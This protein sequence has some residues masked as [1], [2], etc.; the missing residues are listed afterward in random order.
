MSDKHH[1]TLSNVG[2]RCASPNRRRLDPTHYQTDPR[3][4]VCSLCWQ[5]LFSTLSFQQLCKAAYLNDGAGRIVKAQCNWTRSL[6]DLQTS[7]HNDCQWCQ[8]VLLSIEESSLSL[9]DDRLAAGIAHFKLEGHTDLWESDHGSPPKKEGNLNCQSTPAGNNQLVLRVAMGGSADYKYVRFDFFKHEFTDKLVTVTAGAFQWQLRKQHVWQQANQWLRDCTKHDC[10]PMQNPEPLPSRVIDVAS[11][12]DGDIVSLVDGRGHFNYYAALSYPWG[13][14]QVGQTTGRNLPVRQHAMD[15]KSL[16]SSVQDAIWVTRRLGLRYLWV[17]AIC[18]LQDSEEDKVRELKS[19]AAIY[20]QAYVTLL[21]ASSE[22]SSDGFLD[23]QYFVEGS[24]RVLPFWTKTMVLTSVGVRYNDRSFYPKGPLDFRA[25]AF[26]ENL[27]SSRRLLFTP[28]TLQ[29]ECRR[30]RVNLGD[31]LCDPWRVLGAQIF[32]SPG[33]I[34]RLPA[35]GVP[36]RAR[37]FN[38]SRLTRRQSA[39]PEGGLILALWQDILQEYT[40]R[41]LTF[42]EDVLPALSAIAE[43][44]QPF[45]GDQY[46]AG[47]WS[48]SALPV[49]LIWHATFSTTGRLR[50][51]PTEY[52]GP[53]WSWVSDY[54]A[55]YPI[56]LD[57]CEWYGQLLSVQVKLKYDSLPFGPVDHAYL[58]IRATYREARYERTSVDDW[59]NRLDGA[60]DVFWRSKGAG[61]GEKS[62]SDHLRYGESRAR[63]SIDPRHRLSEGNVLALALCRTVNAER[64][65]DLGMIHGLLIVP[66]GEKGIYKR[67]GAF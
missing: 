2:G 49:L 51:E 36:L 60:N 46:L 37:K 1:S 64:W 24:S 40:S 56:A 47:L 58:R 39:G 22:S 14:R 59:W 16:S 54:N 32:I 15:M 10:C 6:Q 33:S 3:D 4:L 17:D 48:G 63:A 65:A 43:A 8:L 52:L 21:A 50:P 25:W 41:S 34:I 31:S 20:R 38:V 13:G 12:S 29:Y 7:A 55:V 53:S 9:N 28:L 67:R 5:Q 27:L 62:R 18:I 61:S 42:Q 66:T 19:M 30:G 26:Q 45:V 23:N 44:F 11:D 35:A 57:W